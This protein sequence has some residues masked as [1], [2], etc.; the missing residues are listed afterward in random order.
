MSQDHLIAAESPNHA[1]HSK[2][3]EEELPPLNEG[4]KNQNPPNIS[5][6]SLLREDLRTHDNNLFE[7]G[8]WAVAVHRFG[9]WRMDIR[10]KVL[11]APVTLCHRFLA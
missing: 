2:R 9:N 11:R 10:P 4:D 1:V 3:D 7:P 5:L 6:L 8:F